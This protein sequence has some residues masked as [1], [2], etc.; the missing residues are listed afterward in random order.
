M[1]DAAQVEAFRAHAVDVK[2]NCSASDYLAKQDD[3]RHWG[4]DRE[5]AKS[6][7]KAGRAKGLHAF[8]LLADAAEGNSRAGRLFLAYVLAIKGRRQLFWSHG[9]KA[10]VGLD[11]K[12]DDEI[13]AEK[14]EKSELVGVMTVSEWKMVVCAGLRATL[15]TAAELGGWPAVLAL[16]DLAS[17]RV[18]GSVFRSP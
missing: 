6:S 8:G 10:A 11:A 14:R 15:L 4:A 17:G 12:T 5:L 7:S 1:D 9:L 16:L 18:P 13:A 3:S 2:G